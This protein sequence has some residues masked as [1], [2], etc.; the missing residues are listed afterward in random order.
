MEC[1]AQVPAVW[2][3]LQL[4][5]SASREAADESSGTRIPL[6]HVGVHME[7]LA[8]GFGSTWPWM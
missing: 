2:F 4:P 6:T 1:L 3:L 8:P 5:V 7:F